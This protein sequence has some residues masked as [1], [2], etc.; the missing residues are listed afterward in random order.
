MDNLELGRR[1]LEAYNAGKWDE[2]KSAL[3]DDV[4]Y[5]E[6]A[7]HTSAS[8][9]DKYVEAV[10]RWKIAFPD[11]K[12]QVL[13]E[14]ASGDT[15]ITEVEWTGTHTGP[16][17]GPLGVIQP[18]SK[19]GSLR[20]VLVTRFANGKIAEVRHY[21]DIMTMLGQLGVLSGLSAPAQPKGAEARPSV[22]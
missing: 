18:T 11:T 8:G 14:Y 22:T 6:L 4:K 15:V 12:A 5:E 9:R 20:A 16:L 2:Y 1:H 7:T 17:E 19:R 13:N 10:K 3:A 21:F